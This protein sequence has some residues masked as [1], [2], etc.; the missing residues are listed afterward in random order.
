MWCWKGFAAFLS[1]V[2]NVPLTREKITVSAY[3]P[4]TLHITNRVIAKHPKPFQK[5]GSGQSKSVYT[6][7]VP[8]HPTIPHAPKT[9]TFATCIP[10]QP[11]PQCVS[12]H[13]FERKQW[14]SPPAEPH[15]K[16]GFACTTRWWIAGERYRQTSKAGTLFPLILDCGACSVSLYHQTELWAT[17]QTKIGYKNMKNRGLA[18]EK[19]FHNNWMICTS[20]FFVWVQYYMFFRVW[21]NSGAE[22][23]PVQ[24]I[25]SLFPFKHSA[26]W[27]RYGGMRCEAA[28]YSAT[29]KWVVAFIPSE[30]KN[31]TNNRPII[32]KIKCSVDN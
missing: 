8:Q 4:A 13:Q 15:F 10:N 20:L 7:S 18:L 17:C 32:C 5:K 6:R 11:N 23:G 24:S 19:Q 22:C 31:Q 9:G 30:E 3:F 27:C 28:S 16:I 1:I 12:C 29:C 25:L 14:R 21:M 26:I 2:P